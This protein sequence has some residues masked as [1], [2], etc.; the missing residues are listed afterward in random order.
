MKKKRS[1]LFVLVFGILVLCSGNTLGVVPGDADG[2]GN[3][4]LKDAIFI[5]Q[6][7]ADIREPSV[8]FPDENL[9]TVIRQA[10]N[11]PTGDIRKSDLQGLT[12]LNAN[13]KKIYNIEGIQYCTNLTK[14]EL[15]DDFQNFTSNQISDISAVAGLTK[16]TYLNLHSNQI[17]DISALAG[18]TNLTRLNLNANQ[19]ND[20]S[21][22]AGLTDLTD[23]G[24]GFNQ[25]SYISAVAGLTKLT[26]LS[27]GWNHQ[28]S[29]ISAVAGL[30]KLTELDLH[31]NQIL[32]ISALAGLTKLTVF[33][34]R[35]NQI[36]DISVL[37]GLTN[38]TNL[39]LGDHIG[40]G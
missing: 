25:I 5:L 19:I 38:L 4:D 3:L 40:V 31:G 26:H 16:L 23:L 32:D 24:L 15:G 29:D 1:F 11:K 13:G 2:S 10:V 12:E 17:S 33:Y 22:V 27:L 14:L 35:Y 18:L 37:A 20:I 36:N 39:N 7:V 6:V 8:S 9:E 30:T 34:F 28:I 21:A